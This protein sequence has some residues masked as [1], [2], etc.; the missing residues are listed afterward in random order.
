MHADE[1]DISADLVRR[2]VADQFPLLND[3]PVTEFESTGTV[4]AIYRLGNELYVRLPRVER[5]WA[6]G[7]QK[8]LKWLP[9]LA[10][11]FTLQVPEPVGVGRPTAE[12]PFTWAVFRWIEGQTYEPGRVDDERQMAADLAGFI[13][14]LRNKEL[15][16]I[17]DETPYGGRPPLAEQDEATRD[18]IAQAGDLIDGPAVIAVWEDALNG[19][20]WDGIYSWIHSD[21]A[22]PNLLVRE[23]RLRAVLDFG[24]TGLGDP[25]TDLNPAWSIFSEDSRHV[26]RDLVGADDDTWR[27][28]R[29]IAISQAVGLV[30]YYA[31]TNPALSALGKRMLREILTDAR[32][33][34]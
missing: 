31:A 19:P 2:L 5:W 33:N 27:R 28:S 7:L 21:L 12:Y 22:P 24:A 32:R 3:H 29:G 8:E 25:A 17:D 13:A 20:A 18:W 30:P 16:A 4:N 11:G 6:R 34:G 23:G 14:E 9:V 10:P 1:V 15:P 26:F